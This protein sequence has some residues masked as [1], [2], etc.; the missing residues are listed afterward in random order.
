MNGGLP[1]TKRLKQLA[2]VQI[3]DAGPSPSGRLIEAFDIVACDGKY[4][5]AGFLRHGQRANAAVL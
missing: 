2:V 1:A 3:K 4:G 5:N